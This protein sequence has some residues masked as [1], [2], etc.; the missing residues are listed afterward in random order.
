MTA[1]RRRLSDGETEIAFPGRGRKDEIGSMA[2]AVEIFRQGA[3]ENKRPEAEREELR[4]RAEQ[5][6]IVAQQKA[7]ADAQERLHVAT[8]GLAGGLQ[9]LAAGDVAFQI[10][11]IFAPYF[12]QLRHDFNRRVKQLG[13]TCLTYPVPSTP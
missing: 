7:E 10:N 11:E 3:I 13:T 5:E 4:Q 8:S 1:V 2:D 9:R 6:R 12:E